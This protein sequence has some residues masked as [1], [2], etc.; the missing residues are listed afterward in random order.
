MQMYPMQM[1]GIPQGQRA[2]FPM[3]GFRPWQ[4]GGPM[5]RPFGY[6]PQRNRPAINRGQMNMG[7]RMANPQRMGGQQRIGQ[8]MQPQ[9]VRLITCLP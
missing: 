1:Y 3:T 9:Q 8:Q 2:Y 4:T 6:M 5:Q 7:N